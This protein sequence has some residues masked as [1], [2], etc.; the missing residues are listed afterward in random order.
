MK[1]FKKEEH[2][3]FSYWF[4]HWCA[5]QMVALNLKCWHP[6]FLLHDIEKP[7]LMFFL[8]RYDKVQL[9]HR[10]NSRHHLSYKDDS[11]ID[12]LAMVID[13]ECSRFTKETSPRTAYQEYLRK[14]NKYLYH[15][16]DEGSAIWLKEHIVPILKKYDLLTVE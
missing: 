9:W 16:K 13:W 14:Y 5:F 8:K 4:A 2:S 11:K 6:R 15:D 7:W 10:R 12:W 1:K 3:S